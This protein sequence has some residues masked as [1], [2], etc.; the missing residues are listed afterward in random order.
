MRSRAD[1]G[2]PVHPR[3]IRRYT[4]P[5]VVRLP[6]RTRKMWRM[7]SPAIT[8]TLVLSAC[9]SCRGSTAFATARPAPNPAGRTIACSNSVARRPMLAAVQT[10]FTGGLSSPFGVAFSSDGRFVFVDSPPPLSPATGS[11]LAVYVPSP[12]GRLVAKMTG[13]FPG[14][15]LTGM[16]RSPDGRY[17]AVANK[18]GAQVFSTSRL[19]RP[20]F[21]PSSWLVGSLQSEGMG[22]IEVTFS[23]DGSYLFVT[24][25]DSSEIAVFEFREG[26]S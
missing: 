20:S 1:V 25:E 13:Q 23:P 5:E 21:S 8:G 6:F 7:S 17:V 9:L 4:V 22:A 24:L 18:S 26:H 16:S 15:Q 2:A 3:R 19:E 11:E 10:T 14:T 12:S